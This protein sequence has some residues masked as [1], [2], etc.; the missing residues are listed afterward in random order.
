VLLLGACGHSL[1]GGGPRTCAS[2]RTLS[3]SH[4]WEE[5]KVNCTAEN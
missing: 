3:F 5:V 1:I 2:H 4:P